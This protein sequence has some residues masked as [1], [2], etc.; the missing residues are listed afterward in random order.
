MSPHP[1][2]PRWETV[3]EQWAQI[4]A[5]RARAKREEEAR[6]VSDEAAGA[7]QSAEPRTKPTAPASGAPSRAHVT[8]H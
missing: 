2:V 7:E 8:N 5:D 3:A 4:R 6:D 1:W